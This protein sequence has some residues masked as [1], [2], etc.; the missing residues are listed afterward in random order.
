LLYEWNETQAEYPSESCVHELFEQQV[1]RTGPAGHG[2]SD[3]RTY[4]LDHHREPVPA[5]AVGE[6][7]VGGGGV[8]RA[9]LNQPEATAEKFVP[10]PFVSEVGARMY[11][12]GELGRWLPGGKVELSARNNSRV[13]IRGFRIEL[14]V[15]EARLAEYP[16]VREAVVIAQEDAP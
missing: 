6:I 2:I 13:T 12:T 1:E 10:D 15:I 3:L 4:I 9:Y 16:G 7:Y 14:G 5:G 8:T 11:K